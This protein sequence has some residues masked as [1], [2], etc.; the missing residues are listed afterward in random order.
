MAVPP[1]WVVARHQ[2]VGFRRVGKHSAARIR[3][4]IGWVASIRPPEKIL[5]SQL[6]VYI[7]PLHVTVQLQSPPYPRRLATMAVTRLTQHSLSKFPVLH[8]TVRQLPSLPDAV[9]LCLL[10]RVGGG[11][12][13]PVVPTLLLLGYRCWRAR[14]TRWRRGR[15]QIIF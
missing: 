9:R 15:L 10:P 14:F 6:P 12:R 4:V 2:V 5:A 3:K 11:A 7:T 13:H 1:A 8:A